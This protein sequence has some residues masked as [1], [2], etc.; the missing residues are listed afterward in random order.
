M[1]TNN[2]T[3]A[4]PLS[5][6]E[7]IASLKVDIASLKNKLALTEEREQKNINFLNKQLSS[8]NYE[9]QILKKD[10][11]NLL[12]LS[13]RTLKALEKSLAIHQEKQK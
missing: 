6:S 11:R 13:K 1:E 9:I 2:E 12:K 8:R 3:I 10:K 7:I 5:G 4:T